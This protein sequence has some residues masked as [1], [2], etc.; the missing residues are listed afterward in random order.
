M[1]S[2]IIAN[3][4]FRHNCNSKSY[5]C[6]NIYSTRIISLLLVILIIGSCKKLAIRN[7]WNLAFK[8]HPTVF[9]KSNY[10]TDQHIWKEKKSAFRITRTLEKI[11]TS[12]VYISG[13]DENGGLTIRYA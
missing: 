1:R 4:D 6:V 8:K 10:L 11:R 13:R 3:C 5:K 7:Y 2:E 12:T 9:R